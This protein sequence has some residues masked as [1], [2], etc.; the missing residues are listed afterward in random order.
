MSLNSNS[1]SLESAPLLEAEAVHEQP[2]RLPKTWATWLVEIALFIGVSLLAIAYLFPFKA[3]Y[4]SGVQMVPS[5][6]FNSLRV[7][8]AGPGETSVVV[9]EGEGNMA[10]VAWDVSH[11][12]ITVEPVLISSDSSLQITI[13]FGVPFYSGSHTTVLYVTL[14]S[15][16]TALNM[17]GSKIHVIYQGPL[18]TDSVSIKSSGGSIRFINPLTLN[19]FIVSTKWGQIETSNITA[20]QSV[21]IETGEGSILTSVHSYKRFQAKCRICAITAAIYSPVVDSITDLSSDYGITAVVQGFTGKYY[22]ETIPKTDQIT[23]IGADADQESLFPVIGWVGGRNS[24][25]SFKA[26]TGAYPVVLVFSK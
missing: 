11:P 3:D 1:G 4:S 25:G 12:S 23:I 9:L 18:I 13:S 5:V 10:K 16:L 15:P 26:V 21:Q 19:N 24:Q 17:T 14:P 6:S 22:V 20:T 7:I 8:T 2:Q